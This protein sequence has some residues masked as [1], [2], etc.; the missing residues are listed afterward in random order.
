MAKDIKTRKGKDNIYYNGYNFQLIF[1][2]YDYLQPIE[3]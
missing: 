1:N 2:N 3:N